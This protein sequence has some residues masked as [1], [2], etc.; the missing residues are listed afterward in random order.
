L[1]SP[2]IAWSGPV[3]MICDGEKAV[4][5]VN[6]CQVC[7]A[8]ELRYTVL[9]GA[10]LSPLMSLSQVSQICWPLAAAP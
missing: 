6:A 5:A 7:P 9:V 4:G 10:L 2:A 1:A 3:A 8:L